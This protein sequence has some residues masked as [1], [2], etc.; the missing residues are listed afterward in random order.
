MAL[1][2]VVP[3]GAPGTGSSGTHLTSVIGWPSETTCLISVLWPGAQ[4]NVNPGVSDGVEVPARPAATCG[5]GGFAG[6]AQPAAS[7]PRRV[8]PAQIRVRVIRMIATS[9]GNANHLNKDDASPS[10]A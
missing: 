9:L 5:A 7:T 2:G 3:T 6:R 10:L 1:S 4:A 8:A